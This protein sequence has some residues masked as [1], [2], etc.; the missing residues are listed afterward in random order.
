VIV[1]TAAGKVEGLERAG[2]L[3]FRGV[4]YAW[5][6]RFR[7]PEP[8]P[9]WSGVLDATQFGPAAPQ[10]PSASDALFAAEHQDYGEDCLV[11]NVYTPAADDRRRPVMVWLHGGGFTSGSGHSPY[12]N[13]TK[14]AQ[15]GDV[16]V[17]TLSYRL[18]ALGFLYLD[19]LADEFA[20]SGVNGIRDQVAALRWVRDNIAT[21]GGDPGRVTIFGESAGAMSVSTLLAAPDA[22]GLFHGAIAQ[23]GAAENVLV[24]EAAMQVTDLVL[25]QLD[26]SPADF[27]QLLD[28]DVD[29]ILTAQSMAATTFLTS[30]P[31]PRRPAS[32]HLQLPFQPVVDGGFLP[33][34]PLDAIRDGSAAGIPLIVGTTADEWNLFALGDALGDIGEERLHRRLG[35]MLGDDG[36]DEAIALYREARPK[37]R[38]SSRLWCAML[39]DRVFRMPAIRLAE[40]QLKYTPDVSMYRFDYRSTAM[41]GVAG[42]CHAIE[43]PFVFDTV[44]HPGVKMLL[45]GVDDGTRLLAR[46]SATAWTTMAQTGR[47]A[48]DDLDWPAYDLD[49]RATCVLNR[50]TSVLDDPEG[51]IRAFWNPQGA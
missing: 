13:G 49:R 10:E 50:T 23:S 9:P 36:A 31:D 44:E 47:P 29:Q 21:F 16:V 42:A 22:A 51:D 27:E 20:G 1:E 5:A 45:G 7:P 24:P 8:A 6:D 4:P 19:H 41:A 25:A 39:T 18:G 15:H 34:H 26:L 28:L 48:H 46:R 40:A 2:I 32:G 35:R 30:R 12:Y 14:L 37:T 33:R 43:I 38:N 11:L 3:Q 17:V